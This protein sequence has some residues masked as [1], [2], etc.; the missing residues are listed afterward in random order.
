[1]NRKITPAVQQEE[2]MTPTYNTEVFISNAEDLCNEAREMGFNVIY[3]EG[4]KRGYV[5]IDDRTEEVKFEG[6][7]G[8]CAGFLSGVK[9]VI[10][11]ASAK[12]TAEVQTALYWRDVEHREARD[13][14]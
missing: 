8:Q 10:A 11:T 12:L 1:M 13:T 14:A 3:R 2:S 7:L 9:Y 4:G 6:Q 5:L